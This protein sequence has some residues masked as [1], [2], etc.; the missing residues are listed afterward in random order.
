VNDATIPVEKDKISEEQ[1]T[2]RVW[3]GRTNDNSDLFLNASAGLTE[4]VF[5]VEVATLEDDS[6]TQTLANTLKAGLNGFQGTVGS[7][8]FLGVFVQDHSDDYEARLLDDD[9]GYY[10]ATFQARAIHL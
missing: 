4:T 6:E 3:F 7:T 8:S 9:Q 10:V 1:P 5:D 2:R